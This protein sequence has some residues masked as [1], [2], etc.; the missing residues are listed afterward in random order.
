MGSQRNCTWVLGLSGF[1]VVTSDG[2]AVRRMFVGRRDRELSPHR[3]FGATHREAGTN[4]PDG[5]QGGAQ[6]CHAECERR[7]GAASSCRPGG[8]GRAGLIGE[9]W[10]S[11]VQSEELPQYVE[12]TGWTMIS[13]G[14]NDSA[15]RPLERDLR[16]SSSE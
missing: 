16:A 6:P 9:S 12:G 8:N 3:I 10:K 7:L 4:Q 1:R 13:A 5:A 15:A 14:D 2:E 11:A